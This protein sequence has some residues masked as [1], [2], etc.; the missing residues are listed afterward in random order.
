MAQSG[1][2]DLAQVKCSFV[3]FNFPV[4]L[5][6]VSHL[7]QGRTVHFWRPAVGRW[8]RNGSW[9]AVLLGSLRLSDKM[10]P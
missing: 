6:N 9:G 2:G 4:C 1:I 7:D 5:E 3:N 10:G 8:N